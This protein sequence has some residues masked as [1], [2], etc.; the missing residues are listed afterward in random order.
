[1]INLQR[2]RWAV[3]LFNTALFILLPFITIN[4][5]SALR[6]DI[7]SLR[8]FFF[9]TSVWIENFFIVL[10]FTFF[11]TFL[12]ILVTQLYGRIWCGWFCPH[13]VMINLTWFFDRKKQTFIQKVISHILVFAISTVISVTIVF[14]FVSPYDFFRDLAAGTLS[15]VTAWFCIV[16]TAITYL[17]FVLIRY[18]FCTTVCPYSK[19]QSIM[20][21]KNTL[22]VAFDPATADRCIKCN[23]CVKTCPVGLDIRKGLVSACINCGRCITACAKVMKKKEHPSLVHYIYGFEKEKKPFRVNVLITAMVTL[24]F[25]SLFVWMAATT[26]PF[27][28]QVLPNQQFMPREKDDRIINS[29]ELII[30][31]ISDKELTFDI[32]VEG[33]DDYELQYEKPFS[34]KPAETVKRTAFLFIEED[35]LED[36]PILSLKMSAKSDNAEMKPIE[37]E[38]SFR[39]PIKAKRKVT[40]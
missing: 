2:Y 5:Q 18:K 12:G 26:K 10:I 6:F 39:R 34:V 3:R 37:S 33:T 31:N 21:D 8:L 29:Y 14:Y 32:S 17:S 1:M 16:I 4:G 24:V 19:L 13:T 20:F 9:G 38:F 23:A 35:E 7:P 28:F 22:I 11:I 36:F 15:S 27:E 40:E 25:F 30:K